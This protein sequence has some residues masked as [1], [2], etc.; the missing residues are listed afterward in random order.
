[1]VKDTEGEGQR[2]V[3]SVKEALWYSE[4]IINRTAAQEDACTTERGELG[5]IRPEAVTTPGDL[6]GT[7]SYCQDCHYVTYIPFKC[8]SHLSK[9][10]G[11]RAKGW[12]FPVA[13]AS[14]GPELGLP[15]L[16]SCAVSTL[17]RFCDHSRLLS[18]SL[19]ARKSQ[20]WMF[21]GKFQG[22]TNW[23]QGRAYSQPA[24][25]LC[26]KGNVRSL[27]NPDGSSHHKTGRCCK[28]QDVLSQEIY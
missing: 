24:L 7:E 17:Q 22:S 12:D 18:H 16:A 4:G 13:L 6:K 14:D 20:P 1:M 27:Q 10:K 15:I 21:W 26:R 9:K 8:Y 5:R 2:Q 25:S 11:K 23:R 19:L 28:I 3:A